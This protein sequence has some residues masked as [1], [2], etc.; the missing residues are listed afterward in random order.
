M[1]PVYDILIPVC[2]DAVYI[3]LSLAWYWYCLHVFDKKASWFQT[4]D[5]CESCIESGKMLPDRN[6]GRPAYLSE[7]V[8]TLCLRLGRERPGDAGRN[9]R[10]FDE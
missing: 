7:R 6:A 5:S 1:I 3:S 2:R 8:G 9:E 4:V 10:I